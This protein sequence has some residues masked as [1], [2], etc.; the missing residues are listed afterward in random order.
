MLNL[1]AVD[2]YANESFQRTAEMKLGLKI[3]GK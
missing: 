1:K 2:Y 3:K